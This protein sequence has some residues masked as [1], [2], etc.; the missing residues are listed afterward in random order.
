MSI[1]KNFVK[2]IN[3][4]NKKY[5]KMRLLKRDLKMS[6]YKHILLIIKKG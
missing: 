3:I 5:I 4:Y 1:I 2:I 6:F